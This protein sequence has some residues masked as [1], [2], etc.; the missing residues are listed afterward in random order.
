MPFEK[1][2]ENKGF[3]HVSIRISFSFL[4][5]YVYVNTMHCKGTSY[6]FVKLQKPWSLPTKE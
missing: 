5:Q 1:K 4:I 2:V 3:V 6:I